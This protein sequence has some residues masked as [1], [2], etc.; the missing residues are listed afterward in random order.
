[1][2]G[3]FAAHVYG[4]DVFVTVSGH[5]GA[6]DAYATFEPTSFKIGSMPVPISMV[7]MQLGKNSATDARETE[8]AG[9][10]K[11]LEGRAWSIGDS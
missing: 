8:I 3:Q 1:M 5:L 9:V 11:R 7:Q 4:K 6:K 2:K 10:R